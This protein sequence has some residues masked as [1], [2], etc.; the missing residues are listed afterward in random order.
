MRN[1]LLIGISLVLLTAGMALAVDDATLQEVENKAE[2]ANA[3][4]D[5]N[6]FISHIL[7]GIYKI[8]MSGRKLLQ[9]GKFML[10]AL[11]S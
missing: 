10:L 7:L 3:K 6:M 1:I 9:R 2:S 8:L 4:A 11:K 5:G